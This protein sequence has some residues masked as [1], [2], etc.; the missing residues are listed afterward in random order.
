MNLIYQA[1][2][3]RW[4]QGMCSSATLALVQWWMHRDLPEDRRNILAVF[5][6]LLQLRQEAGDVAVVLDHWYGRLVPCDDD[7]TDTPDDGLWVPDAAALRAAWGGPWL[8]DGQSACLLVCRDGLLLSWRQHQA[9]QIIVEALRFVQ[10]I[11]GRLSV[12]EA[13][14]TIAALFAADVPDLPQAWQRVAVAT[15]IRNRQEGRR[16]S[17]ITGGPGTGKTTTVA[18]LLAVL[19]MHNQM[20]PAQIRIVAPTGKAAD[21]LAGSLRQA[22]TP[23]PPGTRDDLAGCPLALRA[24]IPCVASTIHSLLGANP[25]TGGLRHHAD[26]PWGLD[27]LILDEASMVDPGL[28]EAVLAALPLQAHLVLVGDPHQLTSVESGCILTDLCTLTGASGDYDA[29]TVS[30]LAPLGLPLPHIATAPTLRGTV[31]TLRHN[32]RAE[33]QRPLVD[34]AAAILAGDLIRAT[35]AANV[36]GTTA[37]SAGT[38]RQIIEII[39]LQ[40]EKIQRCTDI[41][42]ALL[43]LLSFQVLCAQRR[44]PWGAQTLAAA[45]DRELCPIA[46]RDGWYQG[47]AVLI[48]VND[49][50]R[51]LMN[52]DVG[53]CWPIEGTLR[54]IFPRP[55]G[56]LSFATADLPG[57]EPAWALT[58]HKSQGSE[59]AQVHAVLPP[60]ADHPLAIREL[61][62]TAVTRALARVQIWTSPEVFAAAVHTTSNRRSGLVEAFH[63][64]EKS[65]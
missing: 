54:V 35:A 23:K 11:P 52:G 24:T 41:T 47:R 8:D 15:V 61:L 56:N 18:R 21:R 9:E 43:C 31:C 32:F 6:G 30:V 2:E 49:R 33:K 38:V 28:L 60:R 27:L 14:P 19:L 62:Y 17:V 48:T 36:P 42:S 51:G 12:A 1:F 3:N 37:I 13:A 45:V 44:G 25:A 55:D 4:R 59:Y 39:R 22:V 26:H 40:A 16:I 5:A 34:L 20:E 64:L 65:G 29:K 57:H 46:R 63:R 58:I 50:A 7:D 10:I 53:L